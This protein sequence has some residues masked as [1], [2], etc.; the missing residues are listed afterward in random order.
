MQ[1]PASD[2]LLEWLQKNKNRLNLSGIESD[3]GL[4]EKTLR[5]FVS[6][7]RG[8]KPDARQAVLAV[9][10]DMQVGYPTT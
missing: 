7:A 10:K 5:F 6:G 1:A 8:L 4:T 2:L 3:A 9:L